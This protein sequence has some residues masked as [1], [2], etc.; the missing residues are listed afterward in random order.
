MSTTLCPS[1]HH[2]NPGQATH[3][4][5]CGVALAGDGAPFTITLRDVVAELPPPAPRSVP[6]RQAPLPLLD[7]DVP[8]LTDAPQD[9]GADGAPEGAPEADSAW[10]AADRAAKRA[11][12]RRARLRS[13]RGAAASVAVKPE[14][15]VFEP[16]LMVSEMLCSQLRILGFAVTQAVTPSEAA[17]LATNR[18]Y[19]AVFANVAFDGD[20]DGGLGIAMCRT[21]K[22]VGQRHGAGTLFVLV[23]DALSAVDRVRA[24]LAGCDEAL[25]KPVRRTDLARVF[26]TRGIALPF[27]PRR[28]SS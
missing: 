2:P 15:L 13:V 17:A 6:A 14:V 4:A 1:C 8:V 28:R 9:A 11:A 5:V 22:Q 21:V 12:V 19:A 18:P 26:D 23:A 16:D 10:L 25:L 7:D 20:R 27:D 3:C 24:E